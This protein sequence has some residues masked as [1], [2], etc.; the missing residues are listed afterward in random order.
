[1]DLITQD[2]FNRDTLIVAKELLGCVLIKNNPDGTRQSGIIVETEAYKSNDPACHAFRGKTK[3]SITLFKE[4]GLSYVYFTYGMHH[5]MNI[6]TEPYDTAGAVLIRA[7]EPVKNVENTNG[8]AKLCKA[9][10]ITREL[11]EIPVFE[12]D[13]VLQVYTAKKIPEKK[14]IQT[15]RIGIKLAADYPWRFYIK[16]DPFVS[17]PVR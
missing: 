17:K 15:T 3:R 4:P 1:M 7:L 9:M 5:C 14:I 16:G 2:F 8:P 6:V 12:K 10:N 11:N 13:S